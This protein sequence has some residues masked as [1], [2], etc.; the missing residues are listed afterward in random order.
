MRSPRLT[1]TL[2]GARRA[3]HVVLEGLV[4]PPGHGRP[5]GRGCLKGLACVGPAASSPLSGGD[6]H[7]SAHC[8]SICHGDALQFRNLKSYLSGNC[9]ICRRARRGLSSQ[10]REKKKSS[11]SQLPGFSTFSLSHAWEFAP[12]RGA[13]L[14]GTLQGSNSA[15]VDTC[16]QRCV[17][18]P[19]CTYTEDAPSTPTM[20]ESGA[21]PPLEEPGFCAALRTCTHG[22][23]V[24][25]I[26]GSA[27]NFWGSGNTR[28]THSRKDGENTRDRRTGE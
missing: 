22:N 10:K 17:S 15:T 27:G 12:G 28:P 11:R 23:H 21:H 9:L 25:T 3:W 26:E 16:I 1:Q 20:N 19:V 18:L 13:W 5:L 7:Q 8:F 24:S 6:V 4:G 14:Y 2:R